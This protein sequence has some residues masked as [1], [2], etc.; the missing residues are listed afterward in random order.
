M[1]FV[2]Y[3]K[4]ERPHELPEPLAPLADTH[5]HLTPFAGA[6]PAAILCRAAQSGVR[7]HVI[8]IDIVEDVGPQGRFGT[9]SGLLTWLDEQVERAR[10]LYAAAQAAGEWCASFEGWDV[11]EPLDYVRFIAG[12]HPYSAAGLDE[13]ALGRLDELLASPRCVGVGEIGLDFGPWNELGEEV[14]VEAFRTQLRVAHE[15]GLPVELHLRDPEEGE[16]LA[17]ILCERVLTEEG[18]PEAG[19]DLHCYTSGPEIMYPFTNMG[20]YI[21]FG[22]AVTFKR[23]DDI[24]EAACACP[25]QLMLS[26][27]DSPYMAPMPL[28]GMK[29]EPAMIGFSVACVAEE[30][31]RAHVSSRE[32]S[33]RQLWENAQRFFGCV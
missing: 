9:V 20:C 7:I 14:Q 32:E 18:V 13:A 16:P 26:E 6:D 21:A 4:K 33:Y 27:T 24:R 29:C 25:A 5:A 1:P 8:P 11:P 12:A 15:R 28:R 2:L 22:G 23:S 19:C 10:E 3:D 31:E 17:H 30:R